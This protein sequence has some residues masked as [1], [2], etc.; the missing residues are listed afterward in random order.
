VAIVGPTAVGKTALALELCRRAGGEI[1]SMDSRQV[2]RGI[3][4]ATNAPTAAELGGVPCH[5]VGVI[6]PAQ[7]VN[8]ASYADMALRAIEGIQARG[9]LAVLTAGT[10]LYLKALLEGFDLG[11]RAPDAA[12]RA[13]L[14]EL[15][16]R[17]LEG[18]AARLRTLQPDEVTTVD[19]RNPRR[20]VRRVELAVLEREAAPAARTTRPKVPALKIGLTAPRALLY[21]WIEKRVDR[22]LE[23]GLAAEVSALLSAPIKRDSRIDEGIGIK[24]MAEHLCG[25]IPLAAARAAIIQRTRRYA[26]Q[27]WTW[28]RADPEVQ[29]HDV[30]R[31]KGSAIVEQILG[32]LGS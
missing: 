22:M 31:E 20:V 24:E 11:A 16:E 4:I 3:G 19:E 13:E 17:D 29:W 27:Q 28:F 7:A 6:D 10:G 18:L 8:A 14:E 30:A 5:L 25:D 15:A 12:L 21:E 26:K 2:Y 32:M 23:R 1:V 9:R